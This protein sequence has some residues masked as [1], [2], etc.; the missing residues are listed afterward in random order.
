MPSS[1]P[2]LGLSVFFLSFFLTGV[3]VLVPVRASPVPSKKKERKQTT[4]GRDGR[5]ARRHHTGILRRGVWCASRRPPL[6]VRLFLSLFA[7]SLRF[8]HHHFGKSPVRILSKREHAHVIHVIDSTDATVDEILPQT[9]RRRADIHPRRT[10][11]YHLGRSLLR[12]FTRT[13]SLSLGSARIH[14]GALNRTRCVSANAFSCR[15]T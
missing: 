11:P 8:S 14:R 13:A 4:Q 5:T 2:S 12:L 15:T 1:H 6:G 9:S 3:P 7:V 10:G